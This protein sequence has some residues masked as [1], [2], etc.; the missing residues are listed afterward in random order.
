MNG[1]QVVGK[2]SDF[3]P[4]K[5]I[6]VKVADEPVAVVNLDGDLRAFTNLC[7]HNYVPLADGY[8]YAKDNYVMCQ[9]H[10]SIFSTLTGVVIAGAAGEPLTIYDVR[11]EGD[12][13]LVGRKDEPA[14]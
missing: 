13:V 6:G 2:L 10:M 8:G 5:I 4:G 14:A 7:S 1:Y 9:L 3:P 11:I 12:D